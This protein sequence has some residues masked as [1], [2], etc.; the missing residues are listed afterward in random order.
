VSYP[1]WI[2]V[3]GHRIH[4]HLFFELFAYF[5]GFQCYLAL[6]R[7]A[8]DRLEPPVRLWVV[9]AA[10]AGA[11]LGARALYLLECPAETLAR[12]RE[13][14][15]LLAGKT[16][17]GGLAGGWLAVEIVKRAMGIHGR[18]GDLFAVP[19]ALAIAVGRIGCF[20][21]GLA[22]HTYGVATALPWGVDFG[23]GVARHPTQLY[24][25]LYLVFL[26][27]GIARMSSSARLREGDR[28]RVFVV[29]YFG[30]RLL[31]DFLQA[32]RHQPFAGIE[33]GDPQGP[34]L[35]PAAR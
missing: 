3:F 7:R 21:T 34:A 30:F 9:A 1:V 24:E 15:Y 5:S 13:P 22:D 25:S 2:E 32:L 14:A 11:A 8:G 35:L 16:I 12:W 28:F 31:V 23:D 27:L 6:R 29:G 20:L 10:A 33:R 4:P 17:V 26:A 18:T 19:L